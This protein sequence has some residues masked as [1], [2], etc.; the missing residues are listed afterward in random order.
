M[1]ITYY[2]TSGSEAWPA[3]FCGCRAC[4]LAKQYGG[5]NVRTRNQAKIDDTLLL[6]FPPD[7]CEHAQR[8][9]LELGRIRS[10]LVTHSHHDHFFPHDLCMR[11]SNYAEGTGDWKLQVYG[12]PTV[13]RIFEETVRQYENAEDFLEFHVLVPFEHCTT[14]DGYRVTALAADHNPPEQ[15]LLY[16][17]EKGEKSILYAHDTGIFP[18]HTWEY[19]RG[20]HLDCVSLDCTGLERGWRQGHMGFAAVDETVGRLKKQSC[21]TLETTVILSHFAHY[22]AYTHQMICEMENPKGYQVAYD[23]GMFEF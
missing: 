5:K 20:K 4:M 6:D 1:K 22:G 18:E 8:Q 9:G 15:S 12:N 21:V 16:L 3:L 7:T 23:G 10:L 11:S 2:G 14:V 19:L 17:I 13:G